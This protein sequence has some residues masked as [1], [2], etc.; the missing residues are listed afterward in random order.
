M[1]YYVFLPNDSVESSKYSTNILGNE[2]F[3]KFWCDQ[4]FELLSKL[5]DDKSEILDSITIKNDKNETLTVDQFLSRIS[6]LQLV[7]AY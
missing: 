6:K 7:V 4:G 2:S 3:K 5:I 1:Q